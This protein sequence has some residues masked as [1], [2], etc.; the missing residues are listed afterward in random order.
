MSYVT[1]I[2]DFFLA[3]VPSIGILNPT[4]YTLIAE[5][6]KEGIPINIVFNAITAGFVKCKEKSEAIESIA[7]FQEAVKKNQN[8]WLLTQAAKNLTYKIPADIS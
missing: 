3:R 4:D 5:W 2:A 6:E 8:N 7:Y 1:E